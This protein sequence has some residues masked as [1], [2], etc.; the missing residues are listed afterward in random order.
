MNFGADE[1][2]TLPDDGRHWTVIASFVLYRTDTDEIIRAVDQ[3]LRSEVDAHVILV[4]NSV[5]GQAIPDFDPADVTIVRPGGNLGYGG[6]HNRAFALSRGRSSYHLAMNTDVAYGAE[7]LPGLVAY[8]DAHPEAG[9]AMPKVYY[10]DGRLQHLCRLLPHPLDIFARG[11]MKNTAWAKKRDARYEFHDWP[12]DRPASFPF[13]SGCFMFL[14]QSVL[15][16]VG[17]F[18]ERF[19]MYGEDVDLSRRIHE[20]ADTR[21]VPSV[22]VVHEYRTANG[23]DLRRFAIRVANLARYF[24]K[25]GWWFD[26]DRSKINRRTL[27]RLGSEGP[28]ASPGAEA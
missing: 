22:S 20:V 6:A 1:A 9:L 15:E 16:Q 27:E 2:A 26:R 14:R 10:P 28:A 25:W 3:V 24:N 21:F 5:P 23:R 12:H 8:M 11:F 7:V 19:F 17:G 13:L 18:D 4:D